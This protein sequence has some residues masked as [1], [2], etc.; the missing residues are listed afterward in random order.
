MERITTSRKFTNLSSL[1]AI[2]PD[3]PTTIS[4]ESTVSIRNNPMLSNPS[5]HTH[6]HTHTHTYIHT[7]THTHTQPHLPPARRTNILIGHLILEFE[8][9]KV[10]LW[11]RSSYEV[12]WKIDKSGWDKT[13]LRVVSIS[14][15][16][17]RSPPKR[18]RGLLWLINK[19]SLWDDQQEVFLIVG[20][21]RKPH[22]FKVT[23]FFLPMNSLLRAHSFETHTILTNS[24]VTKKNLRGHYY[25][26]FRDERTA[27]Q[28]GCNICRKDE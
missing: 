17:F 9:R 5:T 1:W 25:R 23:I 24:S 21:E 14:F 20:D 11:F 28:S 26:Q 22:V 10:V 12:R 19:K 27:R 6:T 3:G 16:R 15:F 18:N 8:L 4:H 2:K 7:Y 13:S